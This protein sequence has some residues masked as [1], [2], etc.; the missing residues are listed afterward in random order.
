MRSLQ[1]ALRDLANV[2]VMLRLGLVWLVL[3][4]GSG[5]GLWS[6]LGQKGASGNISNYRP[7]SL[8]CVSCKLMERIISDCIL[9]IC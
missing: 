3:G 4:F 5:L 7:I 6:S 1:N 8:T 9:T 2:R